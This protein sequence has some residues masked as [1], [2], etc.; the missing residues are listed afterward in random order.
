MLTMFR[1]G[2]CRSEKEQ[3]SFRQIG[4]LLL[5]Q[6]RPART[7]GEGMRID[8]VRNA[9]HDILLF[10]LHPKLPPLQL[11]SYTSFARSSV[12]ASGSTLYRVSAESWAESR[13]K[14]FLSGTV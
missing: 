8:T 14:S 7:I 3:L 6:E 1:G 13:G 9:L 10:P 11:G 2:W 4:I 12:L 5:I